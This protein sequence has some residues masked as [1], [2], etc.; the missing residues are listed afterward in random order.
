METREYHPNPGDR[1]ITYL[2]TGIYGKAWLP[3]VFLRRVDNKD[4]YEVEL[5]RNRIKIQGELSK[6]AP[7]P[8][9]G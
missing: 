5:D 3:G 7:E 8:G 1:V 9:R 6:I 4:L 2:E